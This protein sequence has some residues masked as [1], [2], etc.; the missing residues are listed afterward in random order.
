ML[1]VKCGIFISLM[2]KCQDV[3]K[4]EYIALRPLSHL[5]ARV[6]GSGRRQ[7]ACLSEAKKVIKLLDK[8]QKGQRDEW[9]AILNEKC[10]SAALFS[11]SFS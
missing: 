2:Q 10:L 11:D 4:E 3:S 1:L 9:A 7:R 5:I 6:S 8:Q